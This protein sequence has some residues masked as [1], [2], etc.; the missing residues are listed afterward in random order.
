MTDMGDNLSDMTDADDRLGWRRIATLLLVCLVIALFGSMIWQ[1]RWMSDDGFINLTVVQNLL[2]GHGPVFNVGERVETYT[3]TLWVGIIAALGTLGIRL[4][5]AAVGGGLV[6]SLVGVALAFFGAK[7]VHDDGTEDRGAL[8]LPLGALVYVSLPPAW[9][10]GTSG[11]ETGLVLTWLG[12][13]YWLT[14]WLALRGAGSTNRT[15]RWYAA[16]AVLGLGPLI[17]PEL[18]LFSLAF[19]LPVAWSFVWDPD[20]GFRWTRLLSLGAAMGAIPVAYQ[21]FRMGYFAALVPNTAIAKEAFSS[22]LE[23]GTAFF[24]DFFGR[25]YL[26]LP[27]G[28]LAAGWLGESVR[29]AR[30]KAWMRLSLLVLPA[31]CGAGYIFYVVAIGGGFMHGRLFLPAIFGLLLPVAAHPGDMPARTSVLGWARVIIAMLVV[32]WSAY[33]ISSIRHPGGIEDGIADERGWY[34]DAAKVENPLLLEDFEKVRF[35]RESRSLRALGES[36]CPSAFDQGAESAEEGDCSPIVRIG[37]NHYMEFG[38][39]FPHRP[40]YPVAERY[41]DRGV[42]LV[43][44]RMSIGIRSLVLGKP[45]HIVDQLGLASPLSARLAI[46]TRG[47][48]GHEKELTNPW[49][50]GRFAEPVPGEDPRIAAARRALGCGELDALLAAVEGPITPGRFAK[51]LSGA[52]R[53]HDLRLPLDPYEA[54]QKFCG[55]RAPHVALAG[56]SGGAERRWR[57]HDGHVLTG[58]SVASSAEEDAIV[59][60][61]PRCRPIAADGDF[62]VGGRVAPAP[63]LGGRKRDAS[64][65]LDCPAGAVVTALNGGIDGVLS[66]IQA[67]CSTVDGGE[68]ASTSSTKPFGTAGGDYNAACPDGEIAVGLAARTGALVDAVGLICQPPDSRSSRR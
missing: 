42:A 65:K 60:I 1:Q 6:L 11:L 4:E 31:V 18:A 8:M 24:D 30:D 22:S 37:R 2:D 59:S 41:A 34:T 38:R 23:Q 48:P 63:R 13:A 61:Q 7:T 17:R 10:Y 33:C 3:S 45:V 62:R 47:R 36:R 26:L 27:L 39:F 54:E 55:R 19:V 29:R 46:A 66:R 43:V 53:F 9:D 20:D 28:L 5:C 25:Y 57:C 51:N 49:V 56:G 35:H 50:V 21:L 64:A 16:G 32:A 67:D 12:G 68:V 44:S 58:L 40:N 52:F 15:W 14:A